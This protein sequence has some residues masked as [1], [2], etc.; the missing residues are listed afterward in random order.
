MTKL[1]KIKDKLGKLIANSANAVT[2][3]I[4]GTD[5]TAVKGAFNREIKYSDYAREQGVEFS[6]NIN[7]DDFAGELPEPRKTIVIVN[8]VEYRLLDYEIDSH[9]ANV[10]LDLTGKLN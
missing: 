8:S 10:R 4:S 5:Y 2:V 9:D 7:K 3:S 1:Q 6:I